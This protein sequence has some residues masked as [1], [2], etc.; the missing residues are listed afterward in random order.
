MLT[1]LAQSPAKIGSQMPV[2]FA[3][4][5]IA[6]SREVYGA[7]LIGYRCCVYAAIKRHDDA[8]MLQRGCI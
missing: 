7:Q 2:E 4:R 8:K 3:V 6:I 1:R 5:M